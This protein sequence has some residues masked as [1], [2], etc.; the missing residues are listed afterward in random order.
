L[1]EKWIGGVIVEKGKVEKSLFYAAKSIVEQFLLKFLKRD[2]DITSHPENPPYS[3]PSRAM[4]VK[5]DNEIV[6]VIFEVN[7]VVLKNFGID[8]NVAMFELNFTKLAELEQHAKKYEP[9]PKFP[10]MA[11]DVSVVVDK[12]LKSA[13]VE[14]TIKDA[15]KELIKKVKL[16][17]IYE[18]ETLGHDKKALAYNITLQAKDRTLNDDEMLKI[19]QRIFANLKALGG[20]IRG[21]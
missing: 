1:E 13:V 9:I 3:H 19:Q 2:F 12:K 18:G 7:P 21:I 14:K 17:D 16:F 6:G 8:A 20:V 10:G 5:V 15:E 4:H 11:I